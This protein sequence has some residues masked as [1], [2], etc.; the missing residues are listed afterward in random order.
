[1]TKLFV[2]GGKFRWLGSATAETTQVSF[3]YISANFAVGALAEID[4][5]QTADT[6]RVY[7]KGFDTGRT[8]EI[9]ALMDSTVITA[10]NLETWKDLCLPDR[11]E[12]WMTAGCTAP[13]VATESFCAELYDYSIGAELDGVLTVTMRFR[14]EDATDCALP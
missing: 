2:N 4:V 3:D 11:L 14:L 5:T 13:T 6:E 1:M 8:I 7:A 12:W 10:A 9:E